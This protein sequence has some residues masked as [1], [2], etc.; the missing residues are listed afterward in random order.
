MK[1]Q[2]EYMEFRKMNFLKN[3]TYN[4]IDVIITLS[5]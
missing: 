2:E 1:M 5:N 3:L 4:K